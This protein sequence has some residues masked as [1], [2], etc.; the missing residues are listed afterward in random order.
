MSLLREAVEKRR[1]E[2]INKLIEVNH[3]KKEEKHLFELTLSELENEYFKVQ[4]NE[5]PHTG[6]DSVKF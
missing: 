2:L 1:K 6:M 3:F 5:H 4:S